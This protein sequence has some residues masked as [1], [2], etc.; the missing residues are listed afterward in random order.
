MYINLIKFIDKREEWEKDKWDIRNL[1]KYGLSYN[2]TLTGNSLNFE[3]IDSIK[4]REAT[5][6]YLKSRLITGDIAFGTSR[7]YIRILTRFFQSITKS[8]KTWNNLKELDRHHIEEYI[9]FLFEYANSKNV[10]SS[11]NFVR[12]ELKAIRRFLNDIVTQN[13]DIAPSEDIRFLIYPQDFPK[14][15]NKDSSKIDYIPDS[16]LEQLFNHINDLHKDLIPVV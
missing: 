7:F 4:M 14:R 3:K 11:R 16:V 9:E 5:K 10:Q 15:E 12:E 6:K 8:E 2:K 13:Y 1:E